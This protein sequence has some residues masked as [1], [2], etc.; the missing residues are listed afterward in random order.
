MGR[1]FGKVR[2]ETVD[3]GDRLSL[4]ELRQAR[5]FSQEVL[6]ERL[7]ARQASVSKLERRTDL[8]LSTLR[9]YVEALGGQLEVIARFPDGAMPIGSF[10]GGKPP[11]YQYPVAPKGR[12]P[13]TL[14]ERTMPM[15]APG[16][17]RRGGGGEGSSPPS[18]LIELRALRGPILEIATRHGASN[19]RVFGSVARGEVRA[20]SDVDLLITAGKKV[21]SWF[22]GGLAAELGELLGRRVDIVT[23][24]AIAPELRERVLEEAVPL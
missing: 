8:H 11:S 4:A 7:G 5:R 14:H 15:V 10:G 19:L 20:D 12:E 23:E 3:A 9:A 6:A 1:K 13:M 21:G 24:Q 16:P 22:P 18:S 17:V 2:E